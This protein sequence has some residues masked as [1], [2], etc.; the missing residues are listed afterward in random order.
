MTSPFPGVDPYLEDQ[1]YWREFH[2]A[3]I[4]WTQD[5]RAERAR[6]ERSID[7]TAPMKLPLSAEDRAWAE[8]IAR[9]FNPRSGR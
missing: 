1:D 4:S 3:F 6:Y 7:Y 9:G 2:K 8:R 5:A